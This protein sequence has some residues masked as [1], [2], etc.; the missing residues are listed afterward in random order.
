MAPWKSSGLEFLV[1]PRTYRSPFTFFFPGLA[2]QA[3]RHGRDSLDFGN[4]ADNG[5]ELCL[6]FLNL[7]LVRLPWT[8]ASPRRF[9]LFFSNPNPLHGGRSFDPFFFF[10]L[11]PP[12]PK[13]R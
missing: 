6:L 8:F 5:I 1:P 10:F 3:L 12:N 13:A 11:N 4:A 9:P 7:Y 2:D